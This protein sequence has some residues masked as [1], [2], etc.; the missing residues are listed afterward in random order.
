MQKKKR[1]RKVKFTIH[2]NRPMN[3][4][5]LNNMFFFQKNF[6]NYMIKSKID[7]YMTEFN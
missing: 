1:E 3:F 7:D 4:L 2:V 6:I 5:K